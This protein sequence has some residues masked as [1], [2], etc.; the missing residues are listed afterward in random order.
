MDSI[1]ICVITSSRADYGLLVEPIKSF[2]NDPQI[3]CKLIVTGSHLSA[4]FGNS[5]KEIEKDGFKIDARVEIE[6]SCDSVLDTLESMGKA[7]SKIGAQIF[8][9]SPDWVLVLGDRYETLAAVQASLI[10]NIPIIHLCGGDITEGAFDDSIRH[11]ITKLSHLHFATTEDSA[12]R[13]VQMGE[14]PN[15]VIVAGSTGLDSLLRRRRM[16]S[17]EFGSSIGFNL[18]HKNI[19]VTFH[20]VT[21]DVDRGLKQLRELVSALESTN[22]EYGIIITKPN[23]DPGNKDFLQEL[24]DFIARRQNTIMIA[25]LGSLLYANAL[26]HC[27]AVV[28]NS[29]SGLYEAPSM[30]IP[31]VNIGDRQKGRILATSVLSV[32]ANHDAIL[33]GIKTALSRGRV[34]TENPYGNGNAT[35]IILSTIKKFENPKTLLKKNFHHA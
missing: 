33:A 25:S 29:S 19:L 4:D 17:E 16:S 26:M 1:R 12:K 27:D 35:Q 22:P 2:H 7:V 3:D 23:S 30:G 5:Y 20:P 21:T 31:T 32:D 10:L 8:Q 11:A 15:S 28:G 18:K 24:E 9:F 6:D 13:I 34:I 14:N